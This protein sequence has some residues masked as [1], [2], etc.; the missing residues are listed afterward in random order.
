[1]LVGDEPY[2]GQYQIDCSVGAK[3]THCLTELAYS[4]LCKQQTQ[5]IISCT[6]PTVPQTAPEI[7]IKKQLTEQGLLQTLCWCRQPP[8]LSE[9]NQLE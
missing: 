9:E 1:M 4:G 8:N 3:L 7:Y 5:L 6:S 2:D